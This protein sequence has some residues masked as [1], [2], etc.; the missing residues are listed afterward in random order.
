MNLK[1]TSINLGLLCTTTV[2]FFIGIEFTLRITGLQTVKPNPPKIYQVSEDSR[3]SYELIPNISRK[4][5]RNTVTTNSIGFRSPELDPNKETVIILGDSIAFGYGVKDEETLSRQISKRTSEYNFLNTAAPGYH[6][7]MQTALYEKKLQQLN[8]AILM[9]IF[10]Y[11]DFETQTGRL[12]ELGIIRSQD[13]QPTEEKCNPINKGI[14]K[15]IPAKCWLD[16]NSAFYKTVKKVVNMRTM[17]NNLQVTREKSKNNSEE[18]SITEEDIYAYKRQLSKLSN[19]LPKKLNRIFVIWP[20][21][22]L[23]AKS[24]PVLKEMAEQEGFLVIDLYET[25]GN[26]AQ[27]LD[28]DTV[29]PSPSTL[30]K[31]AKVIA[32]ELKKL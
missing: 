20:D 23:H 14:L 7:G 5:Y 9:L 22:F 8:P 32:E 1:N 10:H 2:L 25:F 6:L 19:L 21:R 15:Y 30:E 26:E 29:H 4:A 17:K 13:W 27:T 3:I 18:D 28:W 12:D 16:L 24:R 11:N 31:A